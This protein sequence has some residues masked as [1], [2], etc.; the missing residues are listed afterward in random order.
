MP[1]VKYPELQ[2]ADWLREHYDT[3]RMTMY[4]IAALLGCEDGTVYWAMRNHGIQARLMDGYF[5]A[6]QQ[7]DLAFIGID[8]DHMV[9]GIRQARARHQAHVTGAKNRNPHA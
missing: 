8:T 2:D 7:G 9:A 4:E 5:A 1:K 6:L 3:K